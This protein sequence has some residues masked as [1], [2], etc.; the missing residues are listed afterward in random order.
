MFISK[1]NN[2]YQWIDFAST[3]ILNNIDIL[4]NYSLEELDNIY[5]ENKLGDISYLYKDILAVQSSLYDQSDDVNSFIFKGKKYWLDKQQRSCMKTVAE[6]GLENI[7]VVFGDI[8]VTLPAEF[9]KQFILQL[10]AYAYKCYVVTAKH[11]Q[12]IKSL[13]SLEDI[14]NYD[15]KT[16]YPEKLML[17]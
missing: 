8:T 13:Q 2:V 3:N 12:N 1:T 6:C 15:Y 14:I 11:Q 10:E 17:E 9:V 7:E 4:S 16:G 5:K